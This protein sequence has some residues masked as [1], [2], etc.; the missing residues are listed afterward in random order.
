L[1]AFLPPIDLSQNGTF[2]FRYQRGMEN[3]DRLLKLANNFYR[4]AQ[5]TADPM[6]RRA[7]STRANRFRK[8]ADDLQRGAGIVQAAYPKPGQKIEQD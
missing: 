4:Q 7:L 3:K 8:M 5:D 6:I 2:A 1:S